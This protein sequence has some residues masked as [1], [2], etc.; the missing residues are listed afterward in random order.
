[1]CDAVS[2]AVSSAEERQLVALTFLNWAVNEG[3]ES[4]VWEG[5][6]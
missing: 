1:M 5:P 2:G 4:G 3:A 6:L